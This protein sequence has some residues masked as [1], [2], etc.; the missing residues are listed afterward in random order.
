MDM[1]FLIVELLVLGWS[2]LVFGV[3]VLLTTR[4][5]QPRDEKGRFLPRPR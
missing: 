4:K 1:D 5:P 3:A 2:M